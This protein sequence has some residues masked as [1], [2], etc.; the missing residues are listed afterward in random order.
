[1]LIFKK[2]LFF[3]HA[4]PL[5]IHVVRNELITEK[6]D[7]FLPKEKKNLTYNYKT[8]ALFFADFKKKC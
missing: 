3:L 2:I 5:K 8:F 6:L 7:I 4:Y 1:M